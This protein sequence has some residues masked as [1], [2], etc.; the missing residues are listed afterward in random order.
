MMLISFSFFTLYY[1][2][3]PAQVPPLT[4]GTNKKM[5]EALK[6]SFASWEKE[7]ERLGIPKGNNYIH[8]STYL[9]SSS[10][11]S[12]T[13]HANT[14]EKIYRFFFF[15]FF[16]HKYPSAA[17]LET[18]CCCCC[19]YG[20]RLLLIQKAFSSS[21]SSSEEENSRRAGQLFCVYHRPSYYLFFFFP[22][23]DAFR[24]LASRQIVYMKWTAHNIQLL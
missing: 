15:F 24:S 20:K 13:R 22:S 2:D 6:A 5:T 14:N 18:C 9:F 10:F 17:P 1:I 7:Q 19:C 23:F 12:W 4:P 3:I 8:L 11:D 16:K 21:S